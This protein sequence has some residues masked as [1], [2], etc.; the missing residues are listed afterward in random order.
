MSST[1]SFDLPALTCRRLR[2]R[3]AA[4]EPARL[5][6]YLG[7][8]LRG[9]FGHAL[10]TLACAFGPR[11]PCASCL[12]RGS[13]ASTRLFETFVEGPPPPYL[14]GIDTAPRPLVFEPWKEVRALSTGE[15]LGFDLLLFGRAVELE[16]YARLAIERLATNGLGASRTR[17]RVVEVQ[18]VTETPRPAPLEAGALTLR[19]LTPTRLVGNGKF[20]HQPTFQALAFRMLRRH[21][22]LTHFH[23]N[24]AAV[25]WNLGPFMAM[26]KRVEVVARDLRWQDW[27]RYSNR[28][29][30]SI[31]MGGF[32]GS[33][34]LRGELSP[35]LPLLEAAELLH[36]GKGAMLG[37]GH[38]RLERPAVSVERSAAA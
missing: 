11:Q 25:D 19:F 4:E 10:R 14:T 33:M 8:A 7:S 15:E 36:V 31:Q 3:L 32:V 12:L 22:E 24:A 18:A 21:L 6:G 28:Q 13:C 38:L 9:S 37:L 23:G 20:V 1:G 30:T 26:T 29:K 2:V 35:F 5:P 16:A 27:S 17:F 34:T